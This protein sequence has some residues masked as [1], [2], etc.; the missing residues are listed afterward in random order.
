MPKVI[1]RTASDP[2]LSKTETAKQVMQF[3]SLKSLESV[4]SGGAEV[5]KRMHSPIGTVTFLTRSLRSIV[6]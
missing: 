5:A 3:S 4:N 2:E 1:Y 6:L